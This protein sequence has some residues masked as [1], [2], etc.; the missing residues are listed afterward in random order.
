MTIGGTTSTVA[1]SGC[2]ARYAVMRE[3]VLQV[4]RELAGDDGLPDL[5][6]PALGVERVG[7]PVETLAPLGRTEV[8]EPGLVTRLLHQLVHVHGRH[9]TGTL[10]GHE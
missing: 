10:R 1:T 8:V 9:R 6:D 7:E 2:A 5:V 3:P 4:G